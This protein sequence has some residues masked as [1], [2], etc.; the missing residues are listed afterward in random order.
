MTLAKLL[1]PLARV[2]PSSDK[3]RFAWR[4]TLV[5]ALTALAS[6]LLLS[7]LSA[8][9]LG[10]VAIAG[11]TAAAATF[12]FHIPAALIRLFAIGRTAAKYGERFVGHKAALGDQVDRRIALF[13]A[14]ASAPAVRSVG[15]QFGDQDLL[16]DYIDDVEDLDYG[17]LRVNQPLMTL[18]FAIVAMLVATTI[19]VPLALLPIATLLVA[20]YIS[21]CRFAAIAEASTVDARAAR[22]QGAQTFGTALASVV[23]LRAEK[24]WDGQINTALDGF[25]AADA[26][27]MAQRQAQATFDMLTGLLGAL[28][29]ASIIAAAWACGARNEALLVPVF[30][31]FAWL[32]LGETLQT[33]SRLLVAAARR[34]A[35]SIEID[36]WTRTSGQRALVAYASIGGLSTLSV[37]NLQRRSPDGRPI[38]GSFSA[39]FEVGRPTVI[40]GA[41]GCGKTSLLKQIAGW[42]GTDT[43]IVDARVVTAE[44]R[45]DLSVFCPH[46]AAI[47]ADTVRANLFAPTASDGDLWQTLD[48]MELVARI[49]GA[50]GLDGWITQ[51]MLSL[52]E[53]Q[54]LNLARAWLTT[55]PI[56]LLD[57]P[58]EHLDSDQ[59][60]RVLDRLLAHL[61]DRIVVFSSHRSVIVPDIQQIDLT[62]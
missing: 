43:M 59:A 42:I 51:E 50:G 15:W 11:L 20:T 61:A 30:V 36:R 7:G 58:T 21:G 44:A 38:G 22:R 56:V 23:P 41:S 28:I 9:F 60:E 40:A 32:A 27:M 31:A 48:A 4:W 17:R 57:E 2:A 6:G 47:L 12:N 34:N 19:V 8:F 46:D 53:A 37:P 33:L 25:A 5:L 45:R 1:R 18:G 35:A 16:A 55:K 52:G 49:V 3:S 13:S 62:G 39:R 26:R 24:A 10:S 14:M 54:R 29:A